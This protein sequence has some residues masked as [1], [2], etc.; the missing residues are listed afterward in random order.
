MIWSPVSSIITWSSLPYSLVLNV[1]KLKFGDF[2]FE[3]FTTKNL[4]DGIKFEVFQFNVPRGNGTVFENRNF[5]QTEFQVNVLISEDTPE[6]FQT[7]VDYLY[8]KV[9]GVVDMLYYK[10]ADGEIR[11]IEAIGNVKVEKEEHYNITWQ[12][13]VVT[14]RTYGD[15]W[16]S[17]VGQ[18]YLTNITSD[19][20]GYIS[21][22]GNVA[23]QVRTYVIV[24]SASSLTSVSV[25]IAGVACVYTGALVAN[26]VLLFDGV[27]KRVLLNWVEVDYD[28][29]GTPQH[30]IEPGT[31]AYSI[32]CNGTF[33]LDIIM[34]YNK[35]YKNA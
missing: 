28:P 1:D 17:N 16:H 31:S 18:S 9:H 10:R 20:T 29:S 32:D 35:N 12:N 33:D 30:E 2:N 15:F 3:T 13:F 6:E 25:T 4:H 19:D 21:N 5:R 27:N 14:F 23:S 34:L 7:A 26:D 22:G 8:E 24:N 11:K